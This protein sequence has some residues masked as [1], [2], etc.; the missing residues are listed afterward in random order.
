M[1]VTRFFDLAAKLGFLS[2]NRPVGRSWQSA[3]R[4]GHILGA[5][6]SIWTP[7]DSRCMFEGLG[8]LN[9]RS[10]LPLQRPLT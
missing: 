6:T 2:S 3:S 10:D 8:N 4:N 7:K 5:R 1:G 9:L